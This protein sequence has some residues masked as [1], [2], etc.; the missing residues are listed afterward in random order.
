MSRIAYLT[1]E[2]QAPSHT[3]IRREVAALRRNGLAIFPFTVRSG[4][5]VEPGSGHA[6]VQGILDR[7]WLAC[8]ASALKAFFGNPLRALSTWLIAFEHRPPGVRGL[9]WSQFHFLEALALSNMLR[10]AKA[11]HLHCHFANSGATIG[12]MAAHFLRIPWSLTLHGISELDY[13]A[14]FLLPAKLRRAEFVACASWFMRAQ[15]M[16]VSPSHLWSRFHVVRCGT[17]AS[18]AE[19]TSPRSGATG[20]AIIAVGRL[21]PEKGFSGLLQA[22][23]E[24]KTGCSDAQLS[25]VGDGPLR[26]ALQDEA[27]HLG[28]ADSVSFL[29]VLTE[30][31]T[32]ERIAQSDFLVSSSL[33]EGLPLV[34]IEAMALGKAVVAPNIAGIPELVVEGSTGLL[35]RAGDWDQLARKMIAMVANPGQRNEMGRRGQSC[36]LAEFDIDSAVQQLASLFTREHR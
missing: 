33:M 7:G 8:T 11:E 10:A 29:G 36:V 31:K 30:G 6:P 24:L 4:A 3:F 18:F 12:M 13:P 35:Y 19:Q 26:R 27:I 25:I 23:L 17:D 28:L 21:S 20:I 16:R 34:L 9:C 14:G 5:N 2:Y 1:T 15:A 32:R 22:F